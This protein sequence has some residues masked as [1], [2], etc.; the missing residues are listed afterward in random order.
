MI[1]PEPEDASTAF[2]NEELEL[3]QDENMAAHAE[4][5]TEVFD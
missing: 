3:Q 1:E 4:A 2:A 5:Q